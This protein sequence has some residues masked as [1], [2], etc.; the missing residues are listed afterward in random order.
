[1]SGELERGPGP[2]ALPDPDRVSIPDDPSALEADLWAWR[3][4][5]A[6][7]GRPTPFAGPGTTG[8]WRLLGRIGP[9]IVGSLLLVAFLASLASTVRPATVDS[10]AAAP[11]ASS[12]V[13]DG[14][15]GGLLPP[16]IVDVN[17]ATQSTSALRPATL[18]LVP[19]DGANLELL[20]ALYLESSS[21]GIPMAL[22]GP[23]QR[24]ALLERIA[25]DVVPGKIPV[26]IDRTSAIAGSLGL[27][28]QADPTVVVVGTDGRI[29]TV[30]E[31]PAP[32]T[33]LQPVLSR[34]QNGADPVGA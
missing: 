14:Q 30:V 22:V 6:K 18:V 29:H 25:D 21:Y 26:V 33:S 1:M 32:G 24:A 31:N 20:D 3:A 19:A 17:G 7:R 27:P 11:I 10:V 2:G 5:Q 8:A 12:A 15:V 34:A 9:M 28:E 23:P 13:P 4:E 16:G